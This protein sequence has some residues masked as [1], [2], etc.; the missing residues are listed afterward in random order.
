MAGADQSANLGGMLSQMGATLGSMGQAGNGLTRSIEGSF[1]PGV[2]PNDPES[3]R[4][5]QPV[6]RLDPH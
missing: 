2:D 4:R 6:R 3:L 1:M 5:S